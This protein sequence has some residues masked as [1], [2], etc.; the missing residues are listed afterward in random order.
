MTA[1]R[2]RTRPSKAVSRF[3]QAEPEMAAKYFGLLVER[4]EL[5][6]DDDLI[7]ALHA[8]RD[9]VRQ[10]NEERRKQEKQDGK[11]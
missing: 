10:L 9:R 4:V 11:A 7:A 2:R 1:G 6:G 3:E 5:S 8:G